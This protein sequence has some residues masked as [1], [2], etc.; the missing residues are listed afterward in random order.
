M[1]A[2]ILTTGFVT[3]V[4][5][6]V[7]TATAQHPTHDHHYGQNY[8]GRA[9]TYEESV[10]RG[11]AEAAR[12][13]GEY[14]HKT[15]LGV[16]EYARG[17]GEYNRDTSRANIN[18]EIARSKSLDSDVK[19]VESYFQKRD[20]NHRAR[21]N[22][23]ASRPTPRDIARYAKERAPKR[24]GA[25]GYDPEMKRLLWPVVLKNKAYEAERTAIDSLMSERTLDNSGL[26]SENYHEIRHLAATMAGKLKKNMDDVTP[27]EYV[28]AKRFITGIELEAQTTARPSQDIQV[29]NVPLK[30]PFRGLLVSL[31]SLDE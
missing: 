2:I 16:G 31:L 27:T 4:L 14:N 18:N 8:R 30:D 1:K 3:A 19:S 23:S 28:I 6:T 13:M 9:K 22:E 7:G 29:K 21:A 26:G 11:W 17:V 20:I 5:I 24:L 25:Y 15:G 10:L 12:G